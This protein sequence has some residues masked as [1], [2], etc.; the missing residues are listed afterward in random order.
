MGAM[1]LEDS[2]EAKGRITVV[3]GEKERKRK[4]LKNKSGRVSVVNPE[5]CIG[6]GVCALTCPTESLALEWR[7]VIHHPPTDVRDHMRL[8]MSDFEGGRSQSE[9]VR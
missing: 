5:F 2:P 4:E 6:C 1:R 9:Q 8:V 7:E 3:T